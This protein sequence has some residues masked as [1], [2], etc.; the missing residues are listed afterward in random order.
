MEQ[1][2]LERASSI[3][4][5][6][7]LPGSKSVSNRALLLA[8]LSDG[9]TTIHNL[10]RSDDTARMLG[11][12]RA[13]GVGI[14]ELPGGAVEVQGQGGRSRRRGR[15]PSTSATPAPPCAPCARRSPSPL[16]P[17]PSPASRG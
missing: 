5:R 1:L 12:L 4:G 16:A 2:R 6:L 15:W 13:L 8:A 3:Q 14:R 9:T 10:L 11:A 7:D 17:S